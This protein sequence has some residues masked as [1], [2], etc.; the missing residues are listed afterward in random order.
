MAALTPVSPSPIRES[1]GSL[2]LLIYTLTTGS[3][4]DTLVI[5]ANSPVVDQWAQTQGGAATTGTDVTWTASTGTFLL[6]NTSFTGTTKLFVLIR[7]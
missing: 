6:T 3:A 7:T 2:T 5:G 4:S 1:L